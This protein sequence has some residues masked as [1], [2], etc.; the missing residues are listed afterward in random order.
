MSEFWRRVT[1]GYGSDEVTDWPRTRLERVVAYILSRSQ[2]PS[3]FRSDVALKFR[4]IREN[5]IVATSRRLPRSVAYWA[6]IRVGVHA[7]QGPHSGQNPSDL[8]FMDA[9]KRWNER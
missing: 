9:L 3:W 2:H 6:A 4:Q 8:L 1:A 5:L 7:T